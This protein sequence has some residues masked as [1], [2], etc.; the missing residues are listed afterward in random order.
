MLCS[1]RLVFEGKP[2]KQIMHVMRQRV[3]M[4]RF[5][6]KDF[7]KQRYQIK[8][9]RYQLKT[10]KQMN[11]RRF[12]FAAQIISNLPKVVGGKYLRKA[13]MQVWLF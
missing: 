13:Q 8:Y 10:I 9:K 2:G 5:C 6:R 11:K 7:S 1:F 12:I 4:I 3:I